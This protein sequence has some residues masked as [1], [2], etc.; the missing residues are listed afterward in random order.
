L[1]TLLSILK[2]GVGHHQAGRYK[3]A[4]VCYQRVLEIHPDYPDA[5]NLLGLIAMVNSDH[6]LSEQLIRRAI[7]LSSSRSDYHYN[8]GVALS[9]MGKWD[10]AIEAYQ[11]ASHL[12]PKY[13]EPYVN[14]GVIFQKQGKRAVALEMFEKAISIRSDLGEAFYNLGNL[15]YESGDIPRALEMMRQAIRLKPDYKEAL[16]NLAVMLRKS[17]AFQESDAYFMKLLSFYPAYAEAHFQRGLLRYGEGKKEEALDLFMKTVGLNPRHVQALNNVGHLLQEKGAYEEAIAIYKRAL[18]EKATDPEILFN[19]GT[20]YQ[21]RGYIQ[22][23]LDWFNRSLFVSP[24]NPSAIFARGETL[25]AMGDLKEGFKDYQAR[26]RV[27]KW[28]NK[29]STLPGTPLW[30]GASLKG[31]TILVRG[32][33]G[34]GDTIQFARYLPMVEEMGGRVLFEVKKEV[35]P[36]FENYPGVDHLLLHTSSQEFEKVDCYV[37][38]LSLPHLFHTTLSSIPPVVPFRYDRSR[39]KNPLAD[40][41]EMDKKRVGIVWSGSPIHLNDLNRSC[42]SHHFSALFDIKGISFVSL[43][44]GEGAKEIGSFGGL[45]KV[46]DLSPCLSDF[47]DTAL[48]IESLDLVISVDT[49]VAH[50]SGTLGKSTWVLLPFSADFRW[51]MDRETSPW[52]PSMR[53]FRQRA[54]GCWNELFIRVRK[55]L[56]TF[57]EEQSPL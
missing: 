42:P 13:A 44:K 50:L 19:I 22:E 24:D 43:Q 18:A 11:R 36:L 34:F 17:G 9:A 51:L 52:Y 55:A 35:L 47:F 7:A 40:A 30:D 39:R 37:H 23:A 32:E 14:M 27:D 15:C 57:F 41:G 12:D 46:V 21:F 25:L 3:E 38:L 2:E 26:L 5:L 45:K 4:E 16:F 33:Q 56:V 20:A 49:S 29:Y 53:L 1:N 28:K 31:K 54:P 6:S 48:A 10:Q 8:L